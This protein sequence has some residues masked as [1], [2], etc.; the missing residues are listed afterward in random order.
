MEQTGHDYSAD[1][2][3]LGITAIELAQGE[4]PYAELPAMK[5]L[6]K[7]IK[8]EPPQL[9]S[10]RTW[11][12]D[13]RNFIEACL[14]KDASKRPSIDE[15]LKQ[16]KKFFDKAK[17]VSYLKDQFLRT[18]REVYYREDRSLILQ[19]QDYLNNKVKLRVAR[20]EMEK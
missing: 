16:H 4:A 15:L 20:I 2:W 14:Q 19:A 1:I 18:L 13:F 5:V 10:E 6:L 17:P 7:I 12:P 9:S 11:D 8:E 3:S